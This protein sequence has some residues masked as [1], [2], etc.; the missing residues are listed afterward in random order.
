MATVTVSATPVSPAAAAEAPRSSG[1]DRVAF[2]LWVTCALVM[3]A[4]LAYNAV[5]GSRAATPSPPPAPLV[6]DKGGEN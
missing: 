4:M 6:K 5:V 2:L 1:G 3:T